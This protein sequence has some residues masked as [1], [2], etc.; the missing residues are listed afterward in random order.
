MGCAHVTE[1]T[2]E[3]HELYGV[4]SALGRPR[5]WSGAF[6][7]RGLL[8]QVYRLRVPV[9]VSAVTGS[10]RHCAGANE[11]LP[12]A[13]IADGCDAGMMPRVRTDRQRPGLARCDSGHPGSATSG[14]GF[15]CLG[16]IVPKDVVGLSVRWIHRGVPGFSRPSPTGHSTVTWAKRRVIILC[17]GAASQPCAS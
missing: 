10:M 12:D 17:C 1:L 4:A 13:I 6:F 3:R 7:R 15:R 8:T 11:S 5:R 14:G 9:N 2:D 16:R